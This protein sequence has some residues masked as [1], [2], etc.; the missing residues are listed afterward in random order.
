M[1]PEVVALSGGGGE[2]QD[3]MK[4]AD[5]GIFDFRFEAGSPRASIGIRKSTIENHYE[6]PMLLPQFRHL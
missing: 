2:V 6:H 5:F 4:I 1:P 3:R